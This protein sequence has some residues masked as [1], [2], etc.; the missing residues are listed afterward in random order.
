MHVFGAYVRWIILCA[1]E[2]WNAN[3][4]RF[5]LDLHSPTSRMRD[6]FKINLMPGNGMKIKTMNRNAS[7]HSPLVAK[8]LIDRHLQVTK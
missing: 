5:K 7:S 1:A 2:K 4:F 6:S 8:I 3:T